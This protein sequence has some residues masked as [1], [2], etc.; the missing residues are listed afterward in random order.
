M[1]FERR[2]GE[3]NMPLEFHSIHDAN[4]DDEIEVWVT[5][6]NKG[7]KEPKN[8]SLISTFTIP[9]RSLIEYFKVNG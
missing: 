3:L 1:V 8:G 7:G 9:K 2:K 6:K 4:S 5:R